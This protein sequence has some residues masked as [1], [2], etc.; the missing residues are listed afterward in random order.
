MGEI[1]ISCQ[2]INPVQHIKKLKESISFDRFIMDF[3]KLT[4]MSASQPKKKIIIIIMC[5]QILRTLPV[6]KAS[7]SP[8]S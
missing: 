4:V 3:K 7:G 1:V 8:R 5:P 6:K 2:R